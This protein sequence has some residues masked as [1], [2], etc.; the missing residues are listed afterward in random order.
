MRVCLSSMTDF[1]S[2]LG[3]ARFPDVVMNSGPLP[4]EGGLPAPL[5]DTADG[6][7][8]YGSTLLGDLSPYAYGEP[9]YQS[10]QVSYVNHPHRIQKIFP[11]L[12]LPTAIVNSPHVFPISH[13]IDDSDIAF[14]MRLDRASTFCTLLANRS[15]Q[16][17]NMGTAIDP[18]IN[19]CTLNYLLAGLQLY[20]NP[21]TNS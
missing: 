12:L 13:P 9:G 1:F 18:Y 11:P 7:I 15:I 5:H 14:V 6:R 2:G 20:Y 17:H 21:G 4:P 8:N 3:G 16:R 10:S 19:L